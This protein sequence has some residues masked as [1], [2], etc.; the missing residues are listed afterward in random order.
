[1]EPPSQSGHGHSNGFQCGSEK[2]GEFGWQRQCV[3][4]K[5]NLPLRAIYRRKRKQKH[6]KQK[7]WRRLFTHFF[8]FFEKKSIPIDEEVE[9]QSS[10]APLNHIAISKEKRFY[11]SHLCKYDFTAR[12]LF[13]FFLTSNQ[14]RYCSKC[15][16]CLCRLSFKR[17]PK[18]A[19]LF[20][21]LIF[22]RVKIKF[23]RLARFSLDL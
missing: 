7:Q 13:R 1:V 12:E 20:E 16:H 18:T 23:E 8:F 2:S 10:E 4:W 5:L 11:S 15:E 9:K 6:L 3:F 21:F 17:L 19:L 22:A 14:E